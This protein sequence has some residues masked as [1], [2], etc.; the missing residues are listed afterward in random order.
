MLE[1]A[2]TC[3]H[4]SFHHHHHHPSHHNHTTRTLV[5]NGINANVC[6]CIRAST[7]AGRRQRLRRRRLL[8]LPLHLMPQLLLLL[9]LRL[10]LWLHCYCSCTVNLNLTHS[11]LVVSMCEVV[12][13]R[14]LLVVDYSPWSSAVVSGPI[15]S[16]VVHLPQELTQP[17]S[18]SVLSVVL[19]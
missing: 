19:S 11:M 5:R 15:Y 7:T 4:H 1:L 9:R 12:V 6:V 17:F 3:I 8:L 10:R 18:F 14:S 2:A 13:I 16:V